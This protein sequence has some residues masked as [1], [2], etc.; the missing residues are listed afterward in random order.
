MLGRSS[1]AAIKCRSLFSPQPVPLVHQ[2][3]LISLSGSPTGAPSA[4]VDTKDHSCAQGAYCLVWGN[5]DGHVCG[6]GI[7]T[8]DVLIKC[9]CSGQPG[10]QLTWVEPGWFLVDCW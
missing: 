6:H 3:L 5:K 10:E 4:G 1:F 2:N 8:A 9:C 7:E